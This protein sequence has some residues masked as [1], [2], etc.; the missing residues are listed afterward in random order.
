MANLLAGRKVVEEL[1]QREATA[2]NAERLF[3]RAEELQVTKTLSVQDH[4]N[5]AAAHEEA[6]AEDGRQHAQQAAGVVFVVVAKIAGR[7]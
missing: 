4:D 3:K 6:Q 1:I 2:A 5:A 7:K